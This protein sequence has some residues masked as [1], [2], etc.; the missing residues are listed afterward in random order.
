MDI[1]MYIGTEEM[2]IVKTDYYYGL[3]WVIRI[4]MLSFE[5]TW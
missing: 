4:E 2:E 3:K 5:L 1:I